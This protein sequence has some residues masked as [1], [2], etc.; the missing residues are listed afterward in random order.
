MCYTLQAKPPV[1]LRVALAERLLEAVRQE[2]QTHVRRQQR[3][4][5]GVEGRLHRDNNSIVV[6]T[7]LKTGI[8]SSIHYKIQ[9]NLALITS[10]IDGLW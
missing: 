5:D 8:S 10:M 1:V 9:S 6:E 3:E 4:D 2:G 7:S